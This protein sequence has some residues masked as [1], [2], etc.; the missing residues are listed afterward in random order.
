MNKIKILICEDHILIAN[1][2][3]HQ[4]QH[5]QNYEIIGIANTGNDALSILENNPCDIILLDIDLPDTNGLDVLK[6]IRAKYSDLKVMMLSNHTEGWIINK[7]LKNGAN[8]YLSKNAD[9][10]EIKLA[11]EK[12]LENESYFDKVTLTN[13][14]DF[15]Q[16]PNHISNHNNNNNNNAGK[17]DFG[18]AKAKYNHLTKR[19]KEIL[20]LITKEKTTKQMSEILFITTRTIETHRK[21][22]LQKLGVKNSLSIV[23]FVMEAGIVNEYDIEV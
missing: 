1:M 8:S 5:E 21:N 15:I 18:Q 2:I 22:I 23:K 12:T 4:L 19:E 9:I 3:K 14:M 20:F 16:D 13:F 11:I 7:T 10:D 6:T 17:F